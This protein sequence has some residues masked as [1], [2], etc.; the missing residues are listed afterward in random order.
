MQTL[1]VDRFSGQSLGAHWIAGHLNLSPEVRLWID[2]GLHIQLQEGRDYASAGLLSR[3]PVQGDFSASLRFAVSQPAQGTTFELAALRA[4][5]PAHSHLPPLTEAQTA[6]V[7]NVHGEP[8]YV[9]SEFDEN[10]GWRIGWNWLPPV[11]AHDAQGRPYASN[12]NNRYGADQGP[13]PTGPA[14]G[15]LRLSRRQ[16]RIWSAE[17]RLSASAPWQLVQQIEDAALAGPVH[18]RLAAKHWVKHKAG[19]TKAPA[20]RVSFYDFELQQP[21]A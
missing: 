20:N 17:R 5:P 9:S 19:L 10:D 12:V 21:A 1:W 4:A 11:Y 18:L 14:Q 6:L 2:E 8:P 3:V 16:D 7:F 13:K 15:W